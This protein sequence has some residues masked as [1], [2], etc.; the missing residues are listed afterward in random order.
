MRRKM[1]FALIVVSLLPR[2]AEAKMRTLSWI[3]PT[4]YTDNT[5][6]GGAILEYKAGWSYDNTLADENI[7]WFSMADNT[8]IS[9]QFDDSVFGATKDSTIYVTVRAF[10]RNGLGSDKATPY[11][12]QVGADGMSAV[13]QFRVERLPDAAGID[14]YAA[15]F[16]PPQ[17]PVVSPIRYELYFNTVGYDN[18]LAGAKI[19]LG[20]NTFGCVSVG[21][22]TVNFQVAAINDNG[23]VYLSE[24]IPYLHGAIVCDDITNCRVDF[25]H[26]TSLFNPLFGRYLSDFGQTARPSI[27]ECGTG[28]PFVVPVLTIEQRADINGDGRI[29]YRDDLILKSK[30][31][32]RTLR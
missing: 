30:F 26:A 2:I 31:G 28:Q 10:V 12:W 25:A 20:T 21:A 15:S 14:T 29:D 32:N 23:A 11:R 3:A 13:Y 22:D 18:V 9:L 27:P 19:S 16:N 8:L 17:N 7:N 1:L 4:H 24:K 5:L 6:I